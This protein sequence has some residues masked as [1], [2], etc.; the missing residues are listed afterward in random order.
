MS[1]P[2][3][4]MTKKG[5]EVLGLVECQGSKCEWWYGREHCCAIGVIAGGM[6]D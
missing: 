3:V 2:T 5:D 6:I 1:K 4:I